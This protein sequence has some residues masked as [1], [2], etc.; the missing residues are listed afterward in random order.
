M[1]KSPLGIFKS[2]GEFIPKK[3]LDR[4]PRGVR[5]IYVLFDKVKGNK[6]KV[7]YVGKSD[8]SVRGRINAHARSKRKGEKWG[9]CSVFK[10]HDNIS[11]EEI[12]ELESFILFIFRKDPRTIG[13]NT[14]KSAKAFRLIRKMPLEG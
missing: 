1:P 4:I 3:E 11:H 6:Y 2:V 12:K 14:Q 5:G 10:V 13:L 9:H 8:I 7:V